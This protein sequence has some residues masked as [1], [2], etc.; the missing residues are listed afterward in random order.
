MLHGTDKID[1]MVAEGLGWDSV[2][3]MLESMGLAYSDYCDAFVDTGKHAYRVTVVRIDHV[4]YLGWNGQATINDHMPVLV[5][6][7][8]NM[9]ITEGDYQNAHHR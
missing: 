4:T 3:E 8:G 5:D 1:N 6:T 7:D 2:E 9:W